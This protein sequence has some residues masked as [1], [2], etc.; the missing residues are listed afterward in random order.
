MN[1]WYGSVRNPSIWKSFKKCYPSFWGT[2]QNM[3]RITSDPRPTPATSIPYAASRPEAAKFRVLTRS[4]LPRP[5]VSGA[6]PSLRLWLHS[7]AK[8][9]SYHNVFFFWWK[10]TR[11]Y[12]GLLFCQLIYATRFFYVFWY[13]SIKPSFQSSDRVIRV[14][15]RTPRLRR[16]A[17]H[18]SGTRMRKRANSHKF[19]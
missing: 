15:R 7:R 10:L 3:I 4:N 14:R 8:R 18:G 19:N 6:V 13:F 12:F 1:L 17:H 5:T 16:L 9:S 11:I 2:L